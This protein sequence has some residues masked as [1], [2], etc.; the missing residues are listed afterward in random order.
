M[1]RDEGGSE[2]PPLALEMEEVGFN[3]IRVYIL[4]MQ[5]TVAQ[6]IAKGHDMY[7]CK[8]SVQRPTAWVYQR[9]WEQE[10]IFITG[11]RKRVEAAEDTEEER[12]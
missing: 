8:R 9:W 2:Y 7:L 10:G 1:R 3:E 5:D 11:A 6:Y 4:K 12:R